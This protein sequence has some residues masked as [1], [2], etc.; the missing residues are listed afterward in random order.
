MAVEIFE[1]YFD[2]NDRISF[3]DVAALFIQG[4]MKIPREKFD[5]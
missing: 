3:R 2:Y 4:E 5:Q 1:K